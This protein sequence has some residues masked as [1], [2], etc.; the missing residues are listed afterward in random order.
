[1][2]DPGGDPPEGCLGAFVRG[3]DLILSKQHGVNQ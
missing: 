3:L 1:M 2:L